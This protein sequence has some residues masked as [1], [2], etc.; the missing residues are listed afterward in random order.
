MRQFL[1]V[2]LMFLGTACTAKESQ[3]MPPPTSGPALTGESRDLRVAVVSDI[4]PGQGESSPLIA[5]SIGNA[6]TKDR[7][8]WGT[9]IL[10]DVTN[11]ASPEEWNLFE[12]MFGTLLRMPNTRLIAGNHDFEK[13]LEGT[14]GR[15]SILEGRAPGFRYF[16]AEQLENVSLIMLDTGRLTSDLG[17]AQW[18]FLETE[19]AKAGRLR[20]KGATDWIV[21]A[22]HQV[23]VSAGGKR[24]DANMVAMRP[25]FASLFR[26]YGVDVVL[27][28]HQHVAQA[29]PLDGTLFL[30]TPSG[31]GVLRNDYNPSFVSHAPGGD[32]S[33]PDFVPELYHSVYGFLDLTFG[34][35]VLDYRLRGADGRSLYEFRYDRKAKALVPPVTTTVN[36]CLKNESNANL[37]LPTEPPTAIPMYRNEAL[38]R[39]WFT[40]K[41]PRPAAGLRFAI[42]NSAT[43]DAAAILRTPY[44]SK[45]LMTTSNEVFVFQDEFRPNADFSP[46]A[47]DSELE[48]Q[49]I[50]LSPGENTAELRMLRNDA[51]RVVARFWCGDTA[52]KKTFPPDAFVAE[53][54]KVSLVR[55]ALPPC[56]NL[57][58][59]VQVGDA[60]AEFQ[61]AVPGQGMYVQRNPDTVR[62][63]RFSPESEGATPASRV[64]L[65]LSRPPHDDL[66]QHLS[67]LDARGTAVAG[68][69]AT[70]PEKKEGQSVVLQFTPTRRLAT[71]SVY[72]M[73]GLPTDVFSGPLRFRTGAASAAPHTDGSM[74]EA[75][76][77]FF[78]ERTDNP[79]GRHGD[80]DA[81]GVH[82]NPAGLTIGIDASIFRNDL[83][84]AVGA[85]GR[86]ACLATDFNPEAPRTLTSATGLGFALLIGLGANGEIRTAVPQAGSPCAT[87]APAE[88]IVVVRA[89]SALGRAEVFVPWKALGGLPSRFGL[90][91]LVTSA[92]GG[93][94]FGDMLPNNDGPLPAG[95]LA[96]FL[97]FDPD[98]NRDGFPD[99]I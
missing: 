41:T 95:T 15:G 74:S 37:V 7:A 34:A 11:T 67:L 21:V 32:F 20:A 83:F 91:A 77:Y 18:T 5:R 72:K 31:G 6:L 97:E 53:S 81:L 36:V 13:A 35:G 44:R 17:A 25:R 94:A 58:Y 76:P 29:I 28:G 52:E 85:P 93:P 78:E 23:L 84:I 89:P 4:H 2:F 24:N 51:D 14:G 1:T 46:A 56:E 10:G 88:G 64:E 19:L 39:C 92:Q 45:E 33:R 50:R 8:F 48:T 12:S 68:T 96:P 3:P 87:T 71:N 26:K 69:W 9:L 61:P 40:Q 57:V 86:P 98:E 79:W 16:R 62:L 54:A 30:V 75:Y 82:W 73:T 55:I 65:H 38:G 66:T 90:K 43:V 63:V 47:L 59:S 70:I 42:D 22:M 80:I 99:P 60:A 27:G 49:D